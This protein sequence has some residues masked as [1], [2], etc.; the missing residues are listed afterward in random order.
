MRKP[1]YLGLV[2]VFAVS[3]L[4]Y[5][6][7][8]VQ[9]VLGG[10]AGDLLSAIMT[11]GVPHP[12]GYPLYTLLGIVLNNYI[13][14]GTTAFKIGFISTI[15]SVISL[16]L[17][18]LLL[19]KLTA[20]IYPSILSVLILSFSYLFWFYSVVV[21]VFS[22]NNLFL[23]SLFFLGFL[24]YKTGKFR[25][26]YLLTFILGLSLTHHHLI[27]FLLPALIFVVYD[28]FKKFRFK[29]AVKSILYFLLGFTPYLYVFI[30]ARSWPAIN[31]MGQPS[32][33]NFIKLISRSIYG[34]FIAGVFIGQNLWS[35]LLN[36]LGFFELLW[37]DFTLIPLILIMLGIINLY[38]SSRKIFF[39]F[40]I[41]FL[42]YLFFL[43][44]ASFPI[45]DNFMLA[46]FERFLMPLYI[47][48]TI[49]LS[50][51]VIL[52]EKILEYVFKKYLPNL[53][54]L[55]FRKTFLIL[56]LFIPF[57]LFIKNLRKISILKHDF[58]AE[59]F[60][61]DILNSVDKN[62]ILLISEDTPLFDSQYLYYSQI[63]YKDIKL[64][65]FSKLFFPFYIDQLKR[66]YRDL[67]IEK[68]IDS[69][70]SLSVFFQKNSHLNIYSKNNFEITSG[71][72]IPW[73]LVYKFIPKEQAI[74]S[75]EIIRNNEELWKKYHSPMSGS[76]GIAN[77]LF[78]SDI[79]KYYILARQETALYEARKGYLSLAISH[80]QE[81]KN[82]DYKDLDSYI[83]L[84]QVYI[85]EKKCDEADREIS[86]LVK[87]DPGNN[88]AN[89]LKHLNFSLCSDDK[90]GAARWL[91]VYESNEAA[92]ETPLR[93]L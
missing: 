88:T 4:V 37:Q 19:L 22:L 61:E 64:I 51:G 28:K 30:A 82:L 5:F 87:L 2:A 57:F 83:L 49:P 76:L 27:L 79:I 86:A 16:A 31:W 25:Y 8:Q 85:N 89:Y 33:A 60:A 38:I 72:F 68:A 67:K 26:W 62:G 70:K 90:E 71:E 7:T 42:S 35:R 14:W 77:T 93:K 6:P 44:Y 18:Y 50:Y 46:T 10:D 59:Y 75:P 24:F 29:S 55:F 56:L 43:F 11:R 69:E 23:V 45:S 84:S 80:L 92:K 13:P 74:D 20:R 21:E 15:S 66:E 12:P 63:R 73:G 52:T 41:A 17:L 3:S 58:T 53:N 40:L 36:L 39:Y 78:L 47:L 48:L 81:A 54:F 9:T 32:L 1:Y 34:T 91:S 65:H